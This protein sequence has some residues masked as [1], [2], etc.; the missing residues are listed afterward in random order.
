MEESRL[1]LTSNLGIAS[2]FY[3]CLM[4]LMNVSVIGLLRFPSLRSDP[5]LTGIQV[6]TVWLHSGK[7]LLYRLELHSSLDTS[8]VP[9][10]LTNT[11]SVST[12]LNSNW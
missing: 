3:W 9:G 4:R 11:N 10:S 7:L 8:S 6:P 2:I 5:I 12:P 1:E